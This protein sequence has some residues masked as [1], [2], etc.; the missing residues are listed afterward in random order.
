MSNLK[1][2]RT[3]DIIKDDRTDVLILA[4]KTVVKSLKEDY[5]KVVKI[6][7]S[8]KDG[9]W[10]LIYKNEKGKYITFN[11]CLGGGWLSPDFYISNF[12]L[13]EYREQVKRN[14]EK[15]MEDEDYVKAHESRLKLAK[16]LGCE[17][18]SD[19]NSLIHLKRKIFGNLVNSIFWGRFFTLNELQK[20]SF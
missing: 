6:F 20:K 10:N 11:P 3:S 7:A 16:K 4:E 12:N 18:K 13:E 17:I 5:E 15:L 14:H 2:A 8:I 19:L 9:W 1:R